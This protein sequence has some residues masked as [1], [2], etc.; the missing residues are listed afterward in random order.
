MNLDSLAIAW[1]KSETGKPFWYLLYPTNV[2]VC[3]RSIQKISPNCLKIQAKRAMF[4]EISF[5][6][7]NIEIL[8]KM[9]S[10]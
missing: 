10:N 4:T 8:P 9:S 2:I 6:K 3:L 7:H 1:E 5:Q